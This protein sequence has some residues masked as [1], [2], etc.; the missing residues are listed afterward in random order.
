MAKATGT[1]KV[2]VRRK[3]KYL[4]RRYK[5]FRRYSY[6]P[7]FGFAQEKIINMRYSGS[8]LT[9]VA[10]VPAGLSR[11][12][13]LSMNDV[14]VPHPDASGEFQTTAA[15]YKLFANMYD[16]WLVL[17]SKLVITVRPGKFINQ[18]QQTSGTST[19][20]T[21]A[22]PP[23]KWGVTLLDQDDNAYTNYTKWSE[24][25]CDPRTKSRTWVPKPDGSGPSSTIV[26]GYSPRKFWGQ[27]NV[28]DDEEMEGTGGESPA[29]PTKKCFAYIWMQS[30]D[31]STTPFLQHC[32]LSYK[33]Q[34]RVQ[35]KNLHSLG[36]TDANDTLLPYTPS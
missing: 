29:G 26:I 7:S 9:A 23:I 17:G 32:H 33:I 21:G 6:R 31:M 14:Y 3:R 4:R 19:Y 25:V 28:F 18:V 30:E 20:T 34:Y 15:G 11:L 24:I 27:R 35:M 5:R 36:L 1:R 10:S 13:T 2:D 22:W 16:N 8:E 12:L